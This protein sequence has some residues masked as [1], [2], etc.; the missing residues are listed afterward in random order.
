M[1]NT[2]SQTAADAT[3]TDETARPAGPW[4]RLARWARR[5]CGRNLAMLAGVAAAGTASAQE[6]VYAQQPYVTPAP[7]AVAPV[8]SQDPGVIYP[9][10]IPETYQPYPRISPFSPYNVLS[11]NHENQ[12]GTWFQR[13]YRKDRRS[14][15]SA[16]A[17]FFHFNEAGGGVVGSQPLEGATGPFLQIQ[18]TQF[19]SNPQFPFDSGDGGGAGGAGGGAGGGNNSA[20]DIEALDDIL[21]QF[22]QD[23][24]LSGPGVFP[25]PFVATDASPDGLED[26][27]AAARNDLFPVRTLANLGDARGEGVKF[28]YGWDNGDGS[29]VEF[30]GFYTGDAEFNFSRGIDSFA[31]MPIMFAPTAIYSGQLVNLLN[32]SLPLE[33]GLPT[34]NDAGDSLKI[35]GFSQKF[36]VLYE[37]EQDTVMYGGNVLAFAQTI[38]DR[39]ACRLRLFWGADYMYLDE[40]FRFRGIDSGLFYDLEDFQ[41]DGGTIGGGGGG[42]GAGGDLFTGFVDDAQGPAVPSSGIPGIEDTSDRFFEARLTSDTQSHLAGP[43][44]GL[45]YDLGG[46]KDFRVTGTTSFGLLANHTRTIVQGENIGEQTAMKTVYG[47]DFLNDPRTGDPL[48]AGTTAF[49]DSE[50]STHVSPV[51]KQDLNAHLRIGK[52]LPPLRDTDF[53]GDCYLKVGYGLIYAGEVQRPGSAVAWRGYP[54]F[55]SVRSDRES[56]FVQNG[57]IGLEWLY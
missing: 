2:A 29:G 13:I 36:D 12:G 10:Q 16:D 37:L 43:M 11:T 9:P 44:A 55:P 31:G 3:A 45:R 51:L 57:S 27:A 1:R 30:N 5:G 54:L 50:S 38:L 26:L 41:P 4:R 39:D 20:A 49:K 23:F 52:V 8:Y 15:F 22:P 42:G 47:I 40:G 32:G 24:I 6:Q 33:T 48:P 34:F 14:Y 25:Y 35:T 21:E 56:L 19:R 28:Q 53:F 7:P 17:A 46:G 18:P